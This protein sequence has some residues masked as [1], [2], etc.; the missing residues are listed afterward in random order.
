M[1]HGVQCREVCSWWSI[2]PKQNHLERSRVI[3]ASDLD[4]EHHQ[5]CDMEVCES[6]QAD[7]NCEHT[8]CA[9]SCQRIV[10]TIFFET[11]LTWSATLTLVM[12]S[13]DTLLKRKLPKHGSNKT[14][15]VTVH[16]LIQLFRD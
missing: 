4:I 10:G 7:R 1:E 9:V 13:S 8:E 2:T 3:T 6:V 11:P 16:E 12:N 15:Q 5:I 14:A